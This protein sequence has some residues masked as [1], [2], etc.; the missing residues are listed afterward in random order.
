[1]ELDDGLDG[2]LE[3]AD[4]M[5]DDPSDANAAAAHQQAQPTAAP[6]HNTAAAQEEEDEDLLLCL[7]ES[8]DKAEPPA[9]AAAC[10]EF[11]TFDVATYSHYAVQSATLKYQAVLSLPNTASQ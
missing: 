9:S 5:C 3:L 7:A 8:F 1:M 4:A 6:K 11:H 10:G 2:L